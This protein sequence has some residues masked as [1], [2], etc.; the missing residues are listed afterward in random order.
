MIPT[1]DV[2]RIDDALASLD[3]QLRSEAQ[4]ALAALDHAIA[5]E[6]VL[7]A[8]ISHYLCGDAPL[9]AGGGE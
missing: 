1:E 7:R 2:S 9:S 3:A 4:K 5:A 8:A 6:I